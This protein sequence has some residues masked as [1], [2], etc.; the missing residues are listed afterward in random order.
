MTRHLKSCIAAHGVPRGRPARLF[1]LWVEDAHSPLFWLDLEIKA[2]ATLADLDSFLRGIWLECCG[3][4]SSF[5]IEGVRYMDQRYRDPLFD[6]GEHSMNTKLWKAL[7]PETRFEH[8]YDFGT[9]T[10]LKLR[11]VGEREG[12]IGGELLRV[13]SRNEAP[14]WNCMVCDELATE[15][16]IYCMYDRENPFLCEVHAEEHECVDEAFLPVVN[17]PRMGM[18]GYTG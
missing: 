6:F 2:G 7:S 16:C 1:H 17:S 11:V 18:C 4:L 5:E 9:S 8:V 13:L 3:H 14:T 12:R 10:E 15:I